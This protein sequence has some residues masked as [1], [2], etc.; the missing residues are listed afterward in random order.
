[1]PHQNY[2]KQNFK[3]LRKIKYLKNQP[4]TWIEERSHQKKKKKNNRRRKAKLRVHKMEKV[5]EKQA[6]VLT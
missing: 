5:C 2:A 4:R 3:K 6:H 1:M